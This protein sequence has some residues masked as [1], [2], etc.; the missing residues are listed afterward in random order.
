MIKAFFKKR[1][2]IF[3]KPAGTSRGVLYKKPSWYIFIQ[4]DEQPNRTG[5]GECSV[6]PG[7]SIDKEDEIEA[8][9]SDICR[10]INQGFS[11][12]NYSDP[13]FPAIAFGLE[14]ALLDYSKGGNREL[15]PSDFT[16][17][18][19]G[20]LINGLIWMGEYS[21]M[22]KQVEKKLEEG[23]KCI[24]LKIGAIDFEE[25]YKILSGIRKTF[26]ASE[27]EL[28]VDANGAFKAGQA[29]EILKRLAELEIH[30]IE[31]PIKASQLREMAR[32][33]ENSPVP[34]ALDEELLG[35]YPYS[36]KAELIEEIKPQY[37]VLKPGL[38]GGFKQ[39][40]EWI[41]IANA[42]NIK[43]W[44][45]SA[46]ESNIGLN[47]IAQWT[48]TIKSDM[49]QGLGTGSL[50]EQNVNSPLKISSAKLFYQP[51]KKWSYEFVY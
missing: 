47:A 37:I 12:L 7:L 44:I 22:Q 4:D 45:T 33:C 3:K 20:I 42:H 18:R 36:K 11:D 31:Q 32:I 40:E 2:L 21:S 25:E 6:I 16:E 38:L 24:K 46:L 26:A 13:K 29:K 10:D 17:G 48:Y 14:T 51:D 43:W 28:R 39:T 8:R 34:V 49:P 50:F 1:D 9:L 27:L 23:Y 5:I 41:D 35:V 15:Y 19:Q 30:S